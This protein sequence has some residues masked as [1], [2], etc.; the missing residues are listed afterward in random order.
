MDAFALVHFQGNLQ[1]PI[2]VAAFTITVLTS[3]TPS[4][5]IMATLT[6]NGIQLAT[7]TVT[8]RESNKPTKYGLNAMNGVM[9]LLNECDCNE[10]I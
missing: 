4:P 1:R 5:P 9:V 6:L 3:S 7:A 8:T 10:L 2:N